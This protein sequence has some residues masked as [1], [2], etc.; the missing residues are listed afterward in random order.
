MPALVD[1]MEMKPHPEWVPTRETKIGKLTKDLGRISREVVQGR[2][3]DMTIVPGNIL[4]RMMPLNAAEKALPGVEWAQMGRAEVII[5]PNCPQRLLFTSSY[6]SKFVDPL[7][8]SF[9]RRQC[10]FP[11][12]SG[13]L[14]RWN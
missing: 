11:T 1:Y 3:K 2:V 10:S 8:G 6:Q 5:T 4:W 13:S 14:W 9:S 12:S 7:I